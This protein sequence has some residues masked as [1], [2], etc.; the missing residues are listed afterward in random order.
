M[1]ASVIYI[2]LS[3]G[4]LAVVAVLVFILGKRKEANQLTTL[5][6][7]AFS[8]ILAGIIFGENRLVGY[9]LMGVGLILAVIDIVN[10]S[11]SKQEDR[12]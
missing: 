8:F 10:R 2:A 3:I 7:L 4:A 12:Q 5:A 11:R 9:S 6:S 1:N